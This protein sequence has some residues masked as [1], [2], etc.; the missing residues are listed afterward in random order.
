M[1][2]FQTE[3][4]SNPKPRASEEDALSTPP[5]PHGHKL[6]D[7]SQV[8]SPVHCFALKILYSKG[9]SRCRTETPQEWT[10]SSR[11]N[12]LLLRCSPQLRG[13]IKGY[14]QSWSWQNFMR[15]LSVLLTGLSPQDLLFG[16]F[17]ISQN[18]PYYKENFLITDRIFSNLLMVIDS[19]RLPY[20]F[21]HFQ[22]K[23]KSWLIN[24]NFFQL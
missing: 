8:F 9:D 15:G 16:F 1:R 7:L 4:D 21:L 3:R 19:D 14:G 10:F 11:L 5:T 17:S 22:A 6:L 13:T 12:C 2:Y 18:F 24:F 20:N 23:S